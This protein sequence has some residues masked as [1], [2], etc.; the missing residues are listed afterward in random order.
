MTADGGGGRPR[1]S[2][3]EFEEKLS[4]MK[5]K[6][7]AAREGGSATDAEINENWEK[8]LGVGD[9]PK[10]L[11]LRMWKD[12]SSAAREK[13]CCAVSSHAQVI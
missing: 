10:E 5:A 9:L 7:K 12:K 6:L 4:G 13:V 11:K 1:R 3:D 8:V 2:L